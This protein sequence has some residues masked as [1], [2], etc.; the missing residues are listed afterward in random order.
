MILYLIR[1]GDPDYQNNTLT[2][3]GF[4][5]ADALSKRLGVYGLNEVYTSSLPR[6]YLTAQPTCDLLGINPVMCDW[7]KEDHAWH[8]FTV[9]YDDKGNLTWAFFTAKYNRLFNKP[10][11]LALGRNWADSPLFEGENFKKGVELFQKTVDDFL[12]SLGYEHDS[13]N[14]LYKPVNPNEKRVALFAHQGF[15]IAFLSM[16]LD[17]PYPLFASHFDIGHSGV[18]VIEFAVNSEGYVIPKVLQHSNDSHLYREGLPT[19]YQNVLKI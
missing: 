2:P 5:Q 6:A 19:R 17:I 4:K 13:A 16:L 7:A 1:H 10:E 15:G 8:Y 3:Q 12:L 14:G 9:P 11:V 18:C